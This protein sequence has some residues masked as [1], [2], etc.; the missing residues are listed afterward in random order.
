MKKSILIPLILSVP[1]ILSGCDKRMT[2]NDVRASI[3]PYESQIAEM[4][5]EMFDIRARNGDLRQEL[6]EKDEIIE[7]LENVSEAYDAYKEEMSPYQ[8]LADAEAEARR[9]E[10]ES[11]AEKEKKEKEESLAAEKAA[12]EA[13]EKLG[14]D[15]GI[16]YD[17]LARNPENY[18]GEKIKF[19]GKVL[20]VMESDYKVEIRLATSKGYNDVIYCTYSPNIVSSRVL[21]DDRITVYGTSSGT[22]TY[23]S[24]LGGKITIPGM[25]VDKIEQN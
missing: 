15:T 3:A 13:K 19:T 17:Q 16:T 10:A 6:K 5:S 9:I 18:K 24:T 20:Q 22:I 14:Y 2:E 25:H 4:N 23:Q 7:S 12:A 1:I 21:E 8:G 11:I